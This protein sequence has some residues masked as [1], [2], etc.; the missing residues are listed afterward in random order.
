MR[1]TS[2]HRVR[3]TLTI[4]TT[5]LLVGAVACEPATG[6]TARGKL[7]AAAALADYQAMERVFTSDSWVGL[8]A[9]GGRTPLGAS[10]SITALRAIPLAAEASN[11]RQ[12][13]ARLLGE[14]L[15]AHAADAPLARRIISP[16]HL[17]QTL[18]YDPARDQYVV[19]PA[20][21]GAPAEGVRFILYEVDGTGRPILSRE[22]GYA[23]LLD[24]GTRSGETIALRLLVVERGTTRIDY[25]T[26][27]LLRGTSA[28]IDVSGFGVDTDGTRLDFTI[29]ASGENRGGTSRIDLTFSLKVAT[30]NF[31]I[32]GSVRG[33][34]DARPGSGTVDV[35]ARHG[36]D[37]FRVEMTSDGAT[38]SGTIFLNG[39]RF[40]TV[41]GDA[42]NP[43]LLGASGQPV[44][45][46]E[47][48][49][50]RAVIEAVDDVF[51]LVE[52]LVRP[53]EQLLI[54]GWIL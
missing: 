42:T 23:D 2:H 10:T 35:T 8:Q 31:R 12:F 7:D 49:A 54:L 18:V 3:R 27:V 1:Q 34:E 32:E 43:T 11:G 17:G 19:D 14:V 52:D 51:D 48:R 47:L 24:E 53:V 25:R 30:R 39:A 21:S 4:L 50:V 45:E 16:F 6:P 28:R 9:L 20:R 15:A 46:M 37:S 22:I 44:T 13:A 33:V 38:I 29:G 40:V 5:T 36:N 41:A 26:S